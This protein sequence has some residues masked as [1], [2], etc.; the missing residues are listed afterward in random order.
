MKYEAEKKAA[1]EADE[2][3]NAGVPKPR[4]VKVKKKD[5][6]SALLMAG[7]ENSKTGKAKKKNNNGATA[8]KKAS[9]EAEKR[10]IQQEALEKSAKAKGIVMQDHRNEISQNPN[11]P[12]DDEAE[13]ATNIDGAI[14]VLSGTKGL[15]R[16]QSSKN[17]KVLYSAFEAKTI[18]ML[19]EENPG[20]KQSQYKDRCFALWQKSPENPKNQD[21]I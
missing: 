14:E 10:K 16:T 18:P 8:N 12:L 1:L 2:I 19:K 17:L 7:L 4:K 11:R 15:P 6:V 20:L 3:D 9:E 13:T 21:G 5:D